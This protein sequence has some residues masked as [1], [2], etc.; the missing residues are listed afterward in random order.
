MIYNWEKIF[1]CIYKIT[2]PSWKIYI[3]QSQNIKNRVSQYKWMHCKNQTKLYNSFIKYWFDNH[4]FEILDKDIDL[5]EINKIETYYINKYNSV[6]NWLNICSVWWSNR[7]IKWSDEQRK[8]ISE[9][10][11]WKPSKLIWFKRSEETRKNMS[12]SKKWKPSWFKWKT[13]S[14]ES[15]RKMSEQ[16]RW[17]PSWR[18]WKKH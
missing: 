6:D 1:N 4:I 10:K 11:K 7:W 8:K 5:E 16:R 17:K 12:E 14:E 2:S 15:K 18:K 9:L 3:W 13:H